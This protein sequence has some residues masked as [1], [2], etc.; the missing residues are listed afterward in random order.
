MCTYT[1]YARKSGAKVPPCPRQGLKPMFRPDLDPE[2]NYPMQ[3]DTSCSICAV[4]E[5]NLFGNALKVDSDQRVVPLDSV[6]SLADKWTISLV[7]IRQDPHYLPK[8]LVFTIYKTK[9][10]AGFRTPVV[11][12]LI[13]KTQHLTNDEFK[14]ATAR[15]PRDAN[16]GPTMGHTYVVLGLHRGSKLLA[17]YSFGYFPSGVENPDKDAHRT[18]NNEQRLR[19]DYQ[20]TEKNFDEALEKIEKWRTVHGG[21]GKTYDLFGRNCTAFTR[22]VLKAATITFPGDKILSMSKKGLGLVDTPNKTFKALKIGGMAYDPKNSTP[23]LG[24]LSNSKT[25]ALTGYNFQEFVRT[26]LD[27]ADDEVITD[28]VSVL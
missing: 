9:A 27:L 4:C 13:K 5:K 15:A 24:P 14:A 12:F 11:K 25:D 10:L 3:M 1:D 26:S 2:A 6:R 21:E 22:A 8:S 23:I 28:G 17:D 7:A 20:V 18:L 16:N 19:I